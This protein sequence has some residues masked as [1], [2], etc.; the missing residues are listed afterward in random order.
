MLSSWPT[1]TPSLTNLTIGNGTIAAAY[2]Q[3]GKTTHCRGLITLGSTS[4]VTGAAS[5]ALP[6]TAVSFYNTNY[7]VTL[8][9]MT[10]QDVSA[11]TSYL[12]YVLSLTTTTAIFVWQ[13]TATAN[14]TW[15]LS[16]N[17]VPFTWATGDTISWDITY[18]AA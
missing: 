4:S 1:Y 13:N 7:I 2:V 16:S 3:I 9:T 10:S 5:F 11:T 6:V 8:G 12:G 14:S 15:A 18:E 17:T